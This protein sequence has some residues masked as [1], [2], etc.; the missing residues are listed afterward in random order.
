MFVCIS[1][2]ETITPSY[3]KDRVRAEKTVRVHDLTC[4]PRGLLH[5]QHTQVE[6]TSAIEHRIIQVVS[7]REVA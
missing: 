5:G 1:S 6:G 3:L 4:T 7:F 2:D